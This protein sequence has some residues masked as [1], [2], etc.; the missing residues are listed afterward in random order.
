MRSKNKDIVN[1]ENK[2]R[3]FKQ[4]NNDLNIYVLKYVIIS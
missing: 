1:I 3:R 2:E 4:L